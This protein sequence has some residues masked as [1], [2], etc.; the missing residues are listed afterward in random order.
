MPQCHGSEGLGDAKEEREHIVQY[1]AVPQIP[2]LK[3]QRC[4]DLLLRALGRKLTRILERAQ[5]LLIV[6]G[7]VAEEALRFRQRVVFRSLFLGNLEC[8]VAVHQDPF[9][10]FSPKSEARP[11]LGRHRV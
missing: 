11:I 9:T 5:D 6:C 1:E 8:A 10:V 3:H 7:K 2:W 4:D